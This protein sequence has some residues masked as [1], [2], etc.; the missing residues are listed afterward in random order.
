ME[1]TEQS[2]CFIYCSLGSS[3]LPQTSITCPR[4]ANPLKHNKTPRQQVTF[5]KGPARQLQVFVH[6]I[7]S[8]PPRS[9]ILSRAGQQCPQTPGLLL[10][11]GGGATVNTSPLPGT[12]PP[13]GAVL[14]SS[15]F[16][17][18]NPNQKNPKTKHQPLTGISSR[19]IV[20]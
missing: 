3:F 7:P 5:P 19:L 6:Q 18:K 2:A 13:R 8:S 1:N 11:H 14:E 17:Q 12:S 16:T 9:S 15:E 10:A 20:F 4:P